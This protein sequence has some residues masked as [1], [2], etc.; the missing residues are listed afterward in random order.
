MLCSG[1][2]QVVVAG[3][4]RASAPIVSVEGCPTVDFGQTYDTRLVRRVLTVLRVV[5]SPG[6]YR[7]LFENADIVLARNLEMLAIGVYGKAYFSRSYILIYECLDIHSLML[8]REIV[9]RVLRWLEGRLSRWG[10]ALFTSS[11]AFVEH[12]FNALSDVRLPVR[13][14]ENKVLEDEMPR[15]PIVLGM[16]SPGPPWIIGWFGILRCRKSLLILGDLLRRNKGAI[17][18]VLRGRPS[19]EQI[20]DFYQLVAEAD[21]MEFLGPYKNPDDLQAMYNAVHFTWAIDMYQEGQN[22]S[23]LLPN[24][25]YDGAY[26]ASVPVALSSVETGRFLKQHKIGAVLPAPLLDSL[27]AFFRNLTIVQYQNLERVMAEVPRETWAYST[28]DCKALVNYMAAIRSD[29]NNG[30]IR[31]GC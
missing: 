24:R 27:E 10:S 4:C 26:F 13:L 8:G 7:T 1:G 19:F 28:E 29:E 25:L 31:L 16:R 30:T 9:S 17:Q 14:I 21:G 18:V 12:Y 3:F 15:G 22:S 11:L 20:P 2:A 6:R 5:M 23:W